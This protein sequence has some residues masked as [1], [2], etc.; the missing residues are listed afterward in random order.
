MDEKDDEGKRDSDEFL[1][2]AT[3]PDYLARAVTFFGSRSLDEPL[4]AFVRDHALEFSDAAE[5]SLFI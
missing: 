2:C 4:A 1:P 3:T 5:V